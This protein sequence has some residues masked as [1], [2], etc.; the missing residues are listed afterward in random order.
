M[1]DTGTEQQ[2]R[3]ETKYDDGLHVVADFHDRRLSLEI[4]TLKWESVSAGKMLV[5]SERTER[6]FSTFD[7]EKALGVGSG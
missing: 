5:F 6:P 7:D 2:H 1:C 3:E 4:Y